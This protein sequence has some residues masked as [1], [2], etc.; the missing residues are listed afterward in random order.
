[1]KL[2]NQCGHIH[3]QP[4]FLINQTTVHIHSFQRLLKIP[5]QIQIHTAYKG[6]KDLSIY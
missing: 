4:A 3:K 2:G 1:M 6:S 5:V